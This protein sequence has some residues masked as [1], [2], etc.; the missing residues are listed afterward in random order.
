MKSAY[1][2]LLLRTCGGHMRP[3]DAARALFS[4]LLVM[5]TGLKW[6]WMLQNHT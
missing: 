5:D 4:A 1:F 6:Q 2:W 3:W